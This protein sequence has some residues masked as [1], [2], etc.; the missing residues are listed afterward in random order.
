MPD[1]LRDQINLDDLENL[2]SDDDKIMEQLD[3][4]HDV[5]ED[6]Y[7]LYMKDSLEVYMGYGPEMMDGAF[8]DSSDSAGGGDFVRSPIRKLDS[9]STNEIT[10]SATKNSE[11]K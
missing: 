1:G 3:E 4:T 11:C 6:L 10:S 8:T 5:A 9:G 7:D 2:D